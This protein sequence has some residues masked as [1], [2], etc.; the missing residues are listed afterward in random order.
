[1]TPKETFWREVFETSTI[2]LFLF[3]P[4]TIVGLVVWWLGGYF[5]LGFLLGGL[6]WIGLLA[7]GIVKDRTTN[8]GN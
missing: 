8:Y 5:P 4:P 6:V 1:M 7:S 2:P 3:L